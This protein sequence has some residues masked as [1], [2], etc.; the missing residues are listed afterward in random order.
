MSNSKLPS[1]EETRTLRDTL[2]ELLGTCTVSRTV[3]NNCIALISREQLGLK[4]YGQSL[5]D[6]GHSR[7][8]LLQHAREEALDFANYL[9]AEIHTQD[10]LAQKYEELRQAVLDEHALSLLNSGAFPPAKELAP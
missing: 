2:Y 10:V 6:S 3:L 9:E 1:T 8:V 7:R 4:K 5:P